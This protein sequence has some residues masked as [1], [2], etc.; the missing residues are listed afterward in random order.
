MLPNIIVITT[1]Q[2]RKDSL[3]CYGSNFINTPN[4]DRLSA[5]GVRF[6]RAYCTN[7]VCTPSRTSIFSGK[8]PGRHGAWNIGMNVAKEEV[9]ISNL[10]KEKGYRTHLIGKAHFNSFQGDYDQSVESLAHWR[11]RY[12]G[13][14]GPYYGFDEVEMAIGH[15]IGGVTGHY[16]CAVREK[17]GTDDPKDM[18]IVRKSKKIFGG[19]AY[20]WNLPLEQTNALWTA[21]RT[22]EFLQNSASNE[23]PFLLSVGFQD[24][25]HPHAL[26]HEYAKKLNPSGIPLPHY[27]EGE[28]DNKPPHFNMAREGKLNTSHF[29]GEFGIAG[30]YLGDPN[31]NFLDISEEDAQLGRTYY[32]GLV[33]L[34]DY[35]IGMILEALDKLNLS[36]NT[37]VVFTTDHGDLLGDH[38][39]WMKGPFHYEQLINV[40]LIIRWLG[41][42]KSGMEIS[43]LV[44]LADIL[45]TIMSMC[46]FE[47]PEG[48]DGVDL[49][50]VI[51]GEANE[52]RDHI[53]VECTDDPKGLRLKTIVTNRYKLTFYYGQSFGELYDLEMDPWEENNLWE[54]DQMMYIKAELLMK[55]IN[56]FERLEK[57]TIRHSYS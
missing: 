11:E 18:G 14:T 33:E 8:Y 46:S 7:P 48:L 37:I 45:P 27:T 30:H 51:M 49:T 40:P 19:E 21:E 54:I 29:R 20:D 15:T 41:H 34:I 1:D 17:F 4:I 3:G 56:D 6:D 38:G 42:I 47:N 12:P 28:L 5:E 25:H 22:V 36:E 55:L 16:G 35:G 9:F 24:P 50:P 39:L 52:A 10:L 13:F 44:S 31:V 26:P 2:Q 23:S 43:S 57:R 53:L 32:Y